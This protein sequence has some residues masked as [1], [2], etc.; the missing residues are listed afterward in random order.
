M[1]HAMR[2]NR[3]GSPVVCTGSVEICWLVAATWS[4][5]DHRLV[6][7]VALAFL[8]HD[9]ALRFLLGIRVR[10]ALV[11]LFETLWFP[12]STR[13]DCF[14]YV[15]PIAN[16]RTES[17]KIR[18]VKRCLCNIAWLWIKI[19]S[20]LA[21]VQALNS[22]FND[23]RSGWGVKQRMEFECLFSSWFVTGSKIER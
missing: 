8:R 14:W 4:I 17:W 9:S 3:D 15:C 23:L 6:R 19:R 12:C 5:A 13:F 20:V 10:Q 16:S 18:I 11:W 22:R 21:S 7:S 2:Y 1:V